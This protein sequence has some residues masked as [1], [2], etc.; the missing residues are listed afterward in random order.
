MSCIQ[1]E[2]FYQSD[3]KEDVKEA[4][5][6]FT[7]TYQ[8]DYKK[9]DMNFKLSLNQ[10]IQGRKSICE[11]FKSTI[12]FA[13]VTKV[14]VNI[15]NDGLSNITWGASSLRVPNITRV[16]YV[17]YNH[18]SLA[19]PESRF[20]VSTNRQC[21]ELESNDNTYPCCSMKRTCQLYTS[22]GKLVVIK[23]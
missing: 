14:T 10:Y 2:T 15:E 1:V 11:T 16:G 20:L 9:V 12:S 17:S 19:P 4:F 3:F 6:H 23:K 18:Y 22:T 7:V 5:V 13:N 21:E 8:T